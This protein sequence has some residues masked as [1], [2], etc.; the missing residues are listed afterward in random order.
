M[1]QL[2]TPRWGYAPSLDIIAARQRWPLHTMR[3]GAQSDSHAMPWHT[4][5]HGLPY[6][7]ANRLECLGLDTVRQG[8]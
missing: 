8:T 1:P 5:G 2:P 4:F 3:A 6:P 7:L